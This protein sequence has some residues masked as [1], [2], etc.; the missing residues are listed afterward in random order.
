MYEEIKSKFG[1]GTKTVST[2]IRELGL[3]LW[4]EKDGS[5]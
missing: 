5:K 2:E 3:H 1:G 4:S